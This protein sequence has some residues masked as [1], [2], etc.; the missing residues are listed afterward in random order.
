MPKKAAQKISKVTIKGTEFFR[1]TYPTAEGRKREHFATES[2]AKTRLRDIQDE[3]K[4]FGESAL[5]MSAELRSDAIAAARELSGLNITLLDAA[6]EVRKRIQSERGGV[7]VS[8]AV[9]EFLAVQY[10]IVVK[11]HHKTMKTR[12][13]IF[14]Q[15]FAGKSTAELRR[16]DVAQFVSSIPGAAQTRIHYR[17]HISAFVNF[18]VKREYSIDDN[19]TCLVTVSKDHTEP[20]VLTAA[21]AE[22]L[23]LA[24]DSRILPGVVLGLF[25]G[26][27][28][29]EI[30]KITWDAISFEE[31]TVTITAKVAKTSARRVVQ[32]P[33]NAMQWLTPY[34]EAEGMIWPD[35]A[36]NLFN[37]ARIATGFGP[38]TSTA[39]SVIEAQEGKTLE[40]WP[41]NALRHT[42]ISI[43]VAL[44][45]DLARIAY[46]SGNSPKIIKDHYLS[47]IQKSE[48]A[49]FQKINPA[50]SRDVIQ[51]PKVA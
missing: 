27:R 51:F 37:L 42:A 24:C 38:F 15:F 48:A 35:G 26:L 50:D 18:C 44:D 45:P 1:L 16:G 11:A 22:K 33:A 32:I 39:K 13:E 19:L 10:P 14:A 21:Q 41:D 3:A 46:E 28:Q 17:S 5:G 47:L 29:A 4:R 40:P 34:R 9:A 2:A 7:P 8:K 31:S 20:G 12:L 23:I 6:R 30:E 49:K 43:K 36:R 25:C